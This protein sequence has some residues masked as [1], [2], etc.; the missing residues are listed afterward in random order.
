MYEISHKETPCGIEF[1]GSG[2]A[3][4]KVSTQLRLYPPCGVKCLHESV[5]LQKNEKNNF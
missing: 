3:G 2:K 5:S 4:I 1:S